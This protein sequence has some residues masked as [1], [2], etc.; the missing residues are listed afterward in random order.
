MMTI[1]DLEDQFPRAILRNRE[2]NRD[3]I[4]I[5]EPTCPQFYLISPRL[6]WIRYKG[7]GIDPSRVL[8][9]TWMMEYYFPYL[10][11]PDQPI[12]H[13][14]T[15]DTMWTYYTAGNSQQTAC[16]DPTI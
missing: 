16:N 13:H 4:L 8:D 9:Y 15:V 14:I 6:L 2:D 1:K 5:T 10:L 12:R 11:R 3:A 7:G